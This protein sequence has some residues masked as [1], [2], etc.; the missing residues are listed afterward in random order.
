MLNSKQR[1]FLR[2]AANDYECVLFVGKGGLSDEII[3]QA[4][5]ALKTRELIKCKA[6]EASPLTSREAADQIAEATGSEVV[7]VIGRVFVLYKRNPEKPV[8]SDQIPKAG[9]KQ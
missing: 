4:K 2:G 3:N 5:G 6:L 1:A 8:I 7:Q 9:K